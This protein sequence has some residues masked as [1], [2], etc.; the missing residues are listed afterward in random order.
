MSYCNICVKPETK[1]KQRTVRSF[2]PGNAISPELKRAAAHI[3]AAHE[4]TANAR[5]ET[6]CAQADIVAEELAAGMAALNRITGVEGREQ[7]LNEI[8]ASFA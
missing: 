1:E 8:F 7:L 3:Q 4:L 5:P 6:V 2:S